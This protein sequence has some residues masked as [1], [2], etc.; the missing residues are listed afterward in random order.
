MIFNNFPRNIYKLSITIPSIQYEDVEYVEYVE[1]E[2]PTQSTVATTPAA[3][4]PV[5]PVVTATNF[6]ANVVY[7]NV[8]YASRIRTAM[9]PAY[10][11]YSPKNFNVVQPQLTGWNQ[12]ALFYAP[13]PTLGLRA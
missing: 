8:A 10:G 3:M 11:I 1:E 4:T 13:R 2:E 9:V 7:P 12:P 6:P 5:A